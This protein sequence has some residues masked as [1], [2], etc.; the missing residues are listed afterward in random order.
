M[1]GRARA[2]RRF[3]ATLPGTRR[4]EGSSGCSWQAER[5]E[6]SSCLPSGFSAAVT[7]RNSVWMATARSPYRP[8]LWRK[9]TSTRRRGWRTPSTDSSRGK[10]SSNPSTG[11]TVGG[12]IR[13]YF[14]IVCGRDSEK[15]WEDGV[16]DVT[17]S[18]KDL[19]N[20]NLSQQEWMALSE[21][22]FQST[23]NQLKSIDG[24]NRRLEM[25]TA[26]VETLKGQNQAMQADG[27]R[28][29]SAYQSENEQLRRQISER[30]AAAA[31]APGPAALY[32]PNGPQGYQRPDGSTGGPGRGAIG[33]PS[34]VKL[35]SF[36]TAET[37]N[38]TRVAKGN[39][40]YT[41]SINYLPPNSFARARVIVGVDA[42]A[43]VNSQTDPLPVVLRVT[44]PARS[45][46]Q[47]GRL[48]TTRIE[49]CLVNGAARGDLSSETVYVKLQKD[50]KHTSH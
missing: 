36:S 16:N 47:N 45:V 29:L 43:G 28:V 30:Q 5:A 3:R 27:Q 25:L 8:R 6:A 24:Q 38:A 9:A 40:T 11:G 34:E 50:R 20:R 10:I 1:V 39:T 7:A 44:G 35:V 37:G 22:R 14:W 4:F 18:T 23:E 49:G 46:Y 33:G 41:D 13:S 32:G 12:L 48:L 19:V 42:S 26:Q 17:V 15:R 2:S 31:P 21:N